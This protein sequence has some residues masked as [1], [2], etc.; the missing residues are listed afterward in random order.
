MTDST[1][2]RKAAKRMAESATRFV[3]SLTP[4]QRAVAV[5]EFDDDAERTNWH[6]IP[7]PRC[8]LGIVE[9]DESQ[10]HLALDL[11]ATGLSTAAHGRVRTIMELETILGEIEG[12]EGKHVRDPQ[13]YYVSLFGDVGD[14][15]PWGWRFEG[16]HLSLNNTIVDG[17]LASAAPN[18]LGANPA[19]VRHG[20]QTGLRA[21]KAEE[22]IARGLLSDLDG[23]Q[24]RVAI[25]SDR[26]PDDITTR[27]APYVRETLEPPG[28][29]GDDMSTSQQ[30]TLRELIAVYVERL[31]EA[32]AESEIDR[33]EKALMAN[34]HFAWAGA[35]DRGRGHYYRLQGPT[36][37]AEYD[38][39]QNDANH[40]H[41]VWH[42]LTR[43]FGEDLLRSHYQSSHG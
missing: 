36:F 35:V 8:G 37:L 39:T 25:V 15:A 23:D 4:L 42:D 26:A 10:R 3:D 41:A 40:I 19:E 17:C 1:Q 2:L 34:V 7:R 16:H 29:A 33:L 22:D 27:N 11:V 21:L 43:N 24:Q 20:E 18:F 12:A 31:P 28:L 30:Q 6:Y 9:M 38:N 13:L 14:D 5:L 32:L